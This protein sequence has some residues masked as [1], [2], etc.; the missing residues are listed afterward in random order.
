MLTLEEFYM[1]GITSTPKGL[2]V[3]PLIAAI[4]FLKPG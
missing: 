4:P 1:H 3:C 2:A